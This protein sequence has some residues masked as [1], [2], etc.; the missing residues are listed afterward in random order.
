MRKSIEMFHLHKCRALVTN[1]PGATEIASL[2]SIGCDLDHHREEHASWLITSR[3]TTSITCTPRHPVTATSASPTGDAV[4]P[5]EFFPILAQKIRTPLNTIL[6]LGDL[7]LE[8]RLTEE[9]RRYVEVL[10]E[11]GG[12]VLSL[13]DGLAGSV[14]HQRRARLRYRSRARSF[15]MA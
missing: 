10:K 4:A 15:C 2:Q 7:L 12:T 5:S 9:R 1:V 14:G 6:G 13:L 11:V 8:T 3:R